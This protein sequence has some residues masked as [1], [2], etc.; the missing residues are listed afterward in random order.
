MTKLL[1]TQKDRVL[2]YLNYY[3][4]ATVEEIRINCDVLNPL[5]RS[6]HSISTVYEECNGHII[7]R[8]IFN[9]RS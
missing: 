6:G 9:R 8:Y 2:D 3:G 5:R 1:L 4:S 7:G